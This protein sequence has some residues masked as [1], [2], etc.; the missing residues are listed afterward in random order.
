MREMLE[1]KGIETRS[2][3]PEYVVLGYDTEIDYEKTLQSEYLPSCWR[4]I[5]RESP[6]HGVPVTR[7]WTA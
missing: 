2:E 4:P 5:G 1:E 6:R 3:H 7:W